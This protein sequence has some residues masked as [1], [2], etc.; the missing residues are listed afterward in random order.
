MS[1]PER[2]TKTH[3]CEGSLQAEAS[4]RYGDPNF[5]ISK[6]EDNNWWLG[7][8]FDDWEYSVKYI[9]YIF[10]IKHCPFCGQKLE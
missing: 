3:R 1:Y 8:L 7:Y 6:V 10:K 2:F 4:I 9:Y 5:L